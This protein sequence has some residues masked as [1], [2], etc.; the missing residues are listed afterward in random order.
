MKRNIKILLMYTLKVT[1]NTIIGT[2]WLIMVLVTILPVILFSI[3]ERS[4]IT[5]YNEAMLSLLKYKKS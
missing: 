4:M 2:S 3:F 5:Q 1:T